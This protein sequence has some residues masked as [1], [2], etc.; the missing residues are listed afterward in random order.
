M[1]FWKIFKA[2][3]CSLRLEHDVKEEV[4]AEIVDVMISGG[5]LDA[6]LRAPVL[7]SLAE[8]ERLATTGVGQNVA[9]PHIKVSGLQRA[10]ASLCLHPEG[11][12]WGAVDGQPV[13]VF[14]TVLRP[15][16]ESEHHDPLVH[17]EMMRWI[18]RLG[19]ERDFRS[20]ALQATTRAQLLDLLKEMAKV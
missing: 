20:F 9:I 3:S 10:V 6:K 19:R 4:L 2:K 15:A 7:E 1:T 13:Q 12:E 14:F 18:S 11:V 17:L 8:R 5:S 16:E